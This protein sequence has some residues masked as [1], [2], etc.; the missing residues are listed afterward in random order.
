MKMRQLFDLFKMFI[1]GLALCCCYGCTVHR[2]YDLAATPPFNGYVGH[3]SFVT[4]PAFLQ[5]VSTGS[6]IKYYFVSYSPTDHGSSAFFPGGSWRSL[7]LGIGQPITVACTR[8][9]YERADVEASWI[10]S[11]VLLPLN[12]P[13]WPKEVMALFNHGL[14]EPGIPAVYSYF[15]GPGT[16][17][18]GRVQGNPPQ[19]TIQPAPWE[20]VSV[21]EIRRIYWP[22]HAPRL[23]VKPDAL[24]D[25]LQVGDCR[26]KR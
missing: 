24:V 17:W 1:A 18:S 16:I 4:R 9:M 20:P 7:K 13:S 8:L 19:G 5:E 6:G 23:E 3:G 15:I 12:A 25:Q 22:V 10:V 2:A 26:S 14:S 21:P 11:K